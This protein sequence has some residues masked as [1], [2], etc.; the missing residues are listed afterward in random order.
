MQSKRPVLQIVLGMLL[1]TCLM[2]AMEIH[3]LEMQEIPHAIIIPG[4]NGGGGEDYRR[5]SVLNLPENQ[6]SYL[7]TLQSKK[8][9]DLGQNNCI[10]HLEEQLQEVFDTISRSHTKENIKSDNSSYVY[11]PRLMAYAISQ[12]TATVINL[13]GQK[14]HQEQTALVKCL[15]LEAV[16]GS[17]NSAINYTV[18]NFIE[19]T[20]SSLIKALSYIPARSL[21]APW[22]AKVEF[23]SYN[24]LGK[25]ALSS[26]KNIAPDIPVW[27]M[28]NITDQQ[29]DINDARKLYCTLVENGN[30]H[31]YLVET[32]TGTIPAHYNI[33]SYDKNQS[34]KIAALQ[35]FYKKY[36]MPYNQTMVEKMNTS[37]DLAQFQPSIKEVE[38]RIYGLR[39]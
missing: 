19:T 15:V 33:L 4:Q 31:V 7:K 16:L 32:D 3:D 22:I 11:Q 17:G 12:G 13:L 14:S 5:C 1:P 25:Q 21:I 18:N 26:A 38:Y 8:F 29:L 35:L 9:I 23:P 39:K 36:G 37:I 24:P 6:C 28:H 20:E 34:E 2:Q 10:A 30:R 27:I